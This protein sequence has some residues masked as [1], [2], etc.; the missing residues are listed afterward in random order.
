MIPRVLKAK[1]AQVWVNV[2]F[3]N[4]RPRMWESVL[5]AR[6][7]ENEMVAVCT[8]HGNSHPA[9]GDGRPRQEPYAFS[10]NGKIRL[11]DLEEHRYIDDIPVPRGTGRTFYLDTSAHETTLPISRIMESFVI[12]ELAVLASPEAALFGL[13]IPFA[14]FNVP[15][16]RLAA[17]DPFGLPPFLPCQLIGA[18][19]FI[20]IAPHSYK[21]TLPT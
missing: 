15:A 3:Q 16:F 8:L 9:R 7:N 1:G 6:A 2:S 10:H 21:L 4:V 14:S 5:Q 12:G 17:F 20:A 19:L 11:K 18:T 13:A